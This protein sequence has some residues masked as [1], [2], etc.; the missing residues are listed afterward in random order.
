MTQNKPKRL[1]SEAS[2]KHIDEYVGKQLRL[3]RTFL[4]ISQE[5]LGAS[6]DLTFQQVQKYEKG[7]NRISAGRLYEISKILSVPISY[8]FDDIDNNL[9]KLKTIPYTPG[10]AE[11]KSD[12]DYNPM[13]KKESVDLLRAYYNIKSPAVAK[14]IL[15][16]VK[17]VASS[18][19]DEKNN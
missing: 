18:Q 13:K 15:D 1:M 10:L 14:K 5:K 4:G 19:E 6:M 12:F 16:L 9:N 3:R 8:F 17:A 7:L 11:E 2:L